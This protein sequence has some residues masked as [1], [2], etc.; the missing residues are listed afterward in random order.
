M[1]DNLGICIIPHSALMGMALIFSLTCIMQTV[2][3]GVKMVRLD[4]ATK[5]LQL[6]SEGGL[7]VL[8]VLNFAF[9]WALAK[10]YTAPYFGLGA[11]WVNVSPLFWLCIPLAGIH[12]VS[13][14]SD[15]HPLLIADALFCLVNVPLFVDVQG[16]VWCCSY[17]A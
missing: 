9:S 11:F 2:I 12:V 7:L 1:I 8:F 16:M 15:K 3:F 17:A 6:I 4:R 10:G 5:R 13:A 14:F